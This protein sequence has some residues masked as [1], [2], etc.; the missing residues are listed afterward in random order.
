MMFG[1]VGT[2]LKEFQT[3]FRVV[4][5]ESMET[6]TLSLLTLKDSIS[7]DHSIML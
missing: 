2:S 6:I 7:S 4:E 1:E 5:T 3:K